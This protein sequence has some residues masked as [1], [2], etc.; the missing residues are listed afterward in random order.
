MC[1]NPVPV[2][3][4]GTILD[5][6]GD[7]NNSAGF[8]RRGTEKSQD[9]TT[10]CGT[11]FGGIGI[12]TYEINLGGIGIAQIVRARFGRERDFPFFTGPRDNPESREIPTWKCHGNNP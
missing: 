6:I 4:P 5:G 10:V 11:C 2:L 7:I 1:K 12:A 8:A 9:F 3:K